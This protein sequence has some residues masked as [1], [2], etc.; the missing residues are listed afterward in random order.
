VKIKTKNR[1]ADENKS[2]KKKDITDNLMHP[3]LDVDQP[4][5]SSEVV[6]KRDKCETCELNIVGNGNELLCLRCSKYFHEECVPLFHENKIPVIGPYLCHICY[7]L[8]RASSS[9]DSED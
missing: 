5:V 3:I 2:I 1:V 7:Y 9:S 8:H 4:S 6:H